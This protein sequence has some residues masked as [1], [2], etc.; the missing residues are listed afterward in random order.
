MPAS[1]DN[2]GVVIAGGGLS[3][4]RCAE[5][6]RQ[7]G[8]DGSV[9]IVS[10]EAVAPYDRPPLSKA[11]LAGELSVEEIT[12]R[13][14]TW[15]GDKDV[16]LV[17]GDAAAGI[18]LD[19]Q[20]L[21]LASGATVAYEQLVIATGSRP[22]VLPATSAFE[23]VHTLRKLGDAV[24]LQA[25]LHPGVRLVVLG[26]GLIGQ[27]VAA[28]AGKLGAHVTLVEAMDLPLGR[29]LHPEL[30]QWLVEL[31]RAEGVGVRL[32]VGVETF[33]GDGATLKALVLADGSRIELDLLLV[34]IGVQPE[35]E[36]LPAPVADLVARP[37]IFAAGDVAGGD[38][39]EA[40]AHQGRSAARAILGTEPAPAPVTSWWSDIHG[41]RIQG[42]GSPDGADAL[43]IDGDLAERSFTAIATKAGVPVAA[44][45]VGRPRE[46][47][48]LR[49][50][51][52]P[53]SP[54]QETP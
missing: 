31:Q 19:D 38:H 4:Q 32:G 36:W 40:A 26:A 37:E 22:R 33:E 18:N 43:E 7:G 41:L 9:T 27:E 16:A 50:L 23:N 10:A 42:L 13:P 21:V 54:D 47:P 17:L 28:T 6:L 45:A 15:H 35:T 48:R 46:L 29:A 12:F 53:P 44:L 3:A 39:W 8:Y 14:A 20:E 30:A 11:F 2:P 25:A 5:A 49:Q 52:T 34:A 1:T 24:R 51:L